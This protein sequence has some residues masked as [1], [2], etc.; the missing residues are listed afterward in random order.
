[1][2]EIPTTD[3]MKQS[4]L[5]VPTEDLL[6][7]NYFQGFQ[8]PSSVNFANIIKEKH[9]WCV[10][11]EV[12]EDERLKQPIG[13]AIILDPSDK[14]LVYK[15]SARHDEKKIGGNYSWGVGGHILESDFKGADPVR[16]SLMRE[17]MEEVGVSQPG[18]V[19][20]LGYINDDTNPVG[21]VHFGVLYL[22]RAMNSTIRVG[23]PE[24]ESASFLSFKKVEE[25]VANSMNSFDNW[26]LIALSELKRI[27]VS[28]EE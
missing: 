24:V 8:I 2:P 15:R 9:T 23:D 19:E 4:I 25:L 21:R 17:I 22:I 28:K 20:V 1:M 18:K 6:G 14:I 27:I 7:E 13:Y 11:G 10:R 3:K 5:V 16:D 26:S 12:E